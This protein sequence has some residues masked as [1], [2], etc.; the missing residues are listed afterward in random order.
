MSAIP[1]ARKSKKTPCL[2]LKPLAKALLDSLTSTRVFKSR[3][4]SLQ[5]SEPAPNREVSFEILEPRLLLSADI[6]PEVAAVLETGGN[7]FRDWSANLAAYQQLGP[8]PQS[9]L[10]L[11]AH[12]HRGF[13][14]CYL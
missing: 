12:S 3:K 6:A 13:V 11:R 7:E 10:A 4:P 14:R 5:S 9:G 1:K 8:N 2:S